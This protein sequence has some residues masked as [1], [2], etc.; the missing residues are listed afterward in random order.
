MCFATSEFYR[1][2]RVGQRGGN[3]SLVGDYVRLIV[4]SAAGC[5]DTTAWVMNDNCVFGGIND[6]QDIVNISLLP[7]PV[8]DVL[9]VNYQ[10]QTNSAV[11]ISVI[12]ISGRKVMNGIIENQY[13]GKQQMGINVS[14]LANGVY[15]I[16]ISAGNV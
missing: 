6:L 11:T 14:E 15:I 1:K 10:L 4:E 3:F 2:G 12:D 9:Q 5:R 8:N 13:R 16:N 7:N